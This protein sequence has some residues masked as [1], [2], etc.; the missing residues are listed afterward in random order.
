M[1]KFTTIEIAGG[2]LNLSAPGQDFF[3]ELAAIGLADAPPETVLAA[4]VTGNGEIKIW[5]PGF[6]A[7]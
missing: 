5:N 3:N 4:I 2:A 6:I 7:K 1:D